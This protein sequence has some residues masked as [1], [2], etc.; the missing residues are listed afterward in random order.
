MVD[1]EEESP[2]RVDETSNGCG[3]NGIM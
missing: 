1:R 2:E 3:F